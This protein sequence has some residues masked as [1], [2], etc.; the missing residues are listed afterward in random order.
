MQGT[1]VG[2][3]IRVREAPPAQP[4]PPCCQLLPTA[5]SRT[6]RSRSR[7]EAQGS[8]ARRSASSA[9][10]TPQLHRSMAAPY[11]WPSAA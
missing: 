2:W 8:S 7:G 4:L 1:W 9:S 3:C 6:W 5:R 11:G 10:T